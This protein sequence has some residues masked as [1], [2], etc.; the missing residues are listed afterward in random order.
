MVIYYDDNI[1]PVL[2]LSLRNRSRT[3]TC[4]S[5]KA[6]LIHNHSISLQNILRWGRLMSRALTD[7]GKL[8]AMLSL[9]TCLDMPASLHPGKY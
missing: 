6:Y 7:D 8:N 9:T 2:D 3:R 5:L 4:F 1:N